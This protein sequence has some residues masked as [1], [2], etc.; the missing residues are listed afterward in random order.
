MPSASFGK[1]PL[2]LDEVTSKEIL[3]HIYKLR[4]DAWRTKLELPADVAVW[5]DRFDLRAR[6][7]AFFDG[8]RPV[9][10][11]RLTISDRLADVPDAEVYRGVLPADLGGP[12][13]SLTRLVVHP[14]YRGRGLARPLDDVRITSAE[15][16]GCACVIG[17]THEQKRVTQLASEGFEIYAPRNRNSDES[18]I[19]AGLLPIAI[20]MLRLPRSLTIVGGH[21]KTRVQP[22]P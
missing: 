15:V 17:S 16:E 7:W 5:H 22:P 10:A 21:T 18:G 13:G 8:G 4:V 9:A 2:R 11:G 3:E 14:D 1:L 12:I 6:H 20:I 19:L